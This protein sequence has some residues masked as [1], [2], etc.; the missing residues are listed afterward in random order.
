MKDLNKKILFR[1]GNLSRAD[2]SGN[3]LNVTK[4]E[5]NFLQVFCNTKLCN[6]LFAGELNR[7]INKTKNLSKVKILFKFQSKTLLF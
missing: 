5:F 2:I 1:G 3:T 6:L 7:R 4:S